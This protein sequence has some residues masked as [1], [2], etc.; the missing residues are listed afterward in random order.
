MWAFKHK[1][2]NRCGLEKIKNKRGNKQKP[3]RSG[4]KGFFTYGI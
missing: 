2:I 4:A 1:R 3:H